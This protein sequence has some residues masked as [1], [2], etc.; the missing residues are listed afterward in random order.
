MNRNSAS[1]VPRRAKMEKP[2][3]G[4]RLLGLYVP[5]RRL[6]QSRNLKRPLGAQCENVPANN[7]KGIATSSP[8]LASIAYLGCAFGNGNNANGVAAELMP[9]VRNGL[10]TTALRLGRF[11]G[12]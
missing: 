5:S 10:A 12:R 4:F 9:P 7:P 11:D 8:R 2:S 3:E 1:G 6:R